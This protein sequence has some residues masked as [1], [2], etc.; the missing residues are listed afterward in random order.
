M[1]QL[2]ESRYLVVLKSAECPANQ[3]AVLRQTANVQ[4][5]AVEGEY[6]A[7]GFWGD[8]YRH[9]QL[10]GFVGVGFLDVG[11]QIVQA[12]TITLQLQSTFR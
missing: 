6:V 10:D 9:L 8:L 4:H 3:K 12:L 1:Q 2:I 11:H 5:G 7:T